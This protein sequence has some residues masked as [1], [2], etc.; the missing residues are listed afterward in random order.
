MPVEYR[1][2]MRSKDA[3]F[4]FG[5]RRT[6]VLEA[7]EKGIK[8]TARAFQATVRTVRKWVKRYR[9]QG[10]P[11]LEELSRAPKHIPHKTSE[12]VAAVVVAKKRVLKGYGARRMVKEFDLGCGK[13]AALRILKE[14]GLLESRRKKRLRRNDLKDEKAK[15][16]VG[17]VSCVDTKDLTDIPAYWTQMKALDLPQRQYSFREVRTGLMFLGYSEVLSLQHATVF[18]EWILA[19]MEE[20]GLKTPGDRWQTDGGSEFIGSWCAMEKSDFIKALEAKGVRHFQIPKTTYNADVETVHNLI[21][22]EFY[23]IERFKDRRDFFLKASTYQ[24]WFNSVRKN[25]HKWD[26]SPLDILREAVPKAAEAVVTL[27]VLDLDELVRRKIRHLVES[28]SPPGGY[29]VP[30]RA[31]PTPPIYVSTHLKMLPKGESSTH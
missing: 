19:W 14:R 24:R 30:G 11:G 17:E 2:M 15:W 3:V 13:G 7:V 10:L 12:D 20:H 18:A 26:K 6:M 25:S 31:P 9:E 8:P 27:P 1:S 21:E 16:R 29:H 4:R 23:D 5:V 28:P 22:L